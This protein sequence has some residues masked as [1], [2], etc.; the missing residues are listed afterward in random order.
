MV[1]V[2]RYLR[3]HIF[4][5]TRFEPRSL[6]TSLGVGVMSQYQGLREANF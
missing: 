4:L 1:S 2:I 5:C 6:V 3:I